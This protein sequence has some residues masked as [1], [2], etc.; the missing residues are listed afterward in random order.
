LNRTTDYITNYL[1]LI[2]NTIRTNNAPE[3]VFSSTT[4]RELHQPPLLLYI[5]VHLIIDHC[6]NKTCNCIQYQ[7]IKKD[8]ASS[9]SSL[10]FTF[11][12]YLSCHVFAF[13]SSPLQDFCVVDKNS[14]GMYLF[15]LLKYH[16]RMST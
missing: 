10:L 2:T 3:I 8:M 11:M 12:A 9:Y 5:C 1:N 16:I 7:L 4:N 15:Q 13:D 14:Q 6:N